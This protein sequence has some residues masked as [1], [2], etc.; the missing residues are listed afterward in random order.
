VEQPFVVVEHDVDL[1][2]TIVWDAL[3][4]PDLVAGWLAEAVIVPEVGGEYNLTWL[5]R[6]GRPQTF[7]R[8]AALHHPELLIVD[9]SNIGLLEFQLIELP[10]G[11]RGTSTRVR[12]EV[13]LTGDALLA[14]RIAAQW[15]GDLAQL[16]QLLRGYPTDWSLR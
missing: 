12:V 10:G 15:R 1:P 8:I 13:G 3:V 2:R 9:T 16:D 6:V 14:E 4:D 7:G 5:D 11:M